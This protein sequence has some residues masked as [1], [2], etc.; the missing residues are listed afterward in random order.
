MMSNNFPLISVIIPI[1]NVEEYI[2]ACI[3]SVLG[4]TYSNLEI[5]LVDDGSPDN[6]GKICDDYAKKDS[7]I[8]VLHKKNGGLSDARNA[9]L[10]IC[11]GEYIAFV[12]SDD[13]VHLDFINILHK[14]IR[15]SKMIFCD[16]FKFSQ[17]SE[18]NSELNSSEIITL[19][20]EY[21]FNNISTYR[22]P[23][24]IVAWN[25]LYSKDI[26][27]NIRYPKGKIH[28]DEFI[29][30]EIL[31]QCSEVRFIDLPLYLYRQREGSIMSDRNKFLLSKN[32]LIQAKTNRKHFFE[33]KGLNDVASLIDKEIHNTYLGILRNM[34]YK[35]LPN[36]YTTYLSKNFYKFSIKQK[37]KY[38][39]YRF[40]LHGK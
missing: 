28:E 21:V 25:K 3:D 18:I 36:E 30:H 13:I 26:W 16:F 40:G 20:Q 24:L 7:R 14:N 1:Y 5:I 6:C 11:K 38:F 12:D 32:H 22:N 29:A 10:D 15:N 27:D 9:G 33:N 2:S 39:I 17:E 35:Q 23:L 37:M 8:I 34:N 4:Q 19:S 31:D